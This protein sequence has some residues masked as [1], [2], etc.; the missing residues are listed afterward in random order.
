MEKSS[1]GANDNFLRQKF[2]MAFAAVDLWA[3]L[4]IHL[5]NSNTFSFKRKF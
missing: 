4:P 5:K 2:D 1:R 3:S